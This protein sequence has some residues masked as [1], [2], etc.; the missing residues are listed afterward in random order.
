MILYT[1]N[2]YDEIVKNL[3]VGQ[4]PSDVS[5]FKN[6]LCLNGR[7]T[8]NI[9]IWQTVVTAPFDDGSQLPPDE[10]LHKL[11]DL[12]NYLSTNEKTLVHCAAG[13]NRSA[14]IAALVLMKRGYNSSN[15]IQTIRTKRDKEC[16]N[17]KKF[18]E[19]LHKQ[20]I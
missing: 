20:S 15:A 11:G 13:I 12:A 19:W 4:Y 3:Y 6:V 8:Y 9:E 5:E 7:A 17:N 1:M 14:M 18:V 2:P 10:F 16:L